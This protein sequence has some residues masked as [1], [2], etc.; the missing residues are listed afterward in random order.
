[1]DFDAKMYGNTLQGYAEEALKPLAELIAENKR[2][3]LAALGTGVMAT[4]PGVTFAT[5]NS[6]T[7]LADITAAYSYASSFVVPYVQNVA[8]A[9]NL[10]NSVIALFRGINVPTYPQAAG[11]V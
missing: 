8:N 4:L 2:Y 3:H 9:K 1:M 10:R 11:W 7:A 5:A 6:T